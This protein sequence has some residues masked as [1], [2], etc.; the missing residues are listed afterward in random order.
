MLVAML[1]VLHRSAEA[2][3][4]ST[5]IIVGIQALRSQLITVGDVVYVTPKP[6]LP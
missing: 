3:S 4:G 5:Q 6:I 2:Q 1:E